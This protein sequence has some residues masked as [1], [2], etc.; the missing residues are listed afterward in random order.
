MSQLF[1]EDTA[2]RQH[3]AAVYTCWRMAKD[4]RTSTNT[5]VK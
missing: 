3:S 4:R 5:D 2:I 1:P